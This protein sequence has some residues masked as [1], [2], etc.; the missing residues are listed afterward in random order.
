MLSHQRGNYRLTTNLKRK[1]VLEE[2]KVFE[3]KKAL[4]K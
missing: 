2:K 4:K 3:E 1:K